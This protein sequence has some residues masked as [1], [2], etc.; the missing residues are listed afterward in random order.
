MGKLKSSKL[1]NYDIIEIILKPFLYMGFGIMLFFGLIYYSVYILIAKITKQENY[2]GNIKG[3]INNIR[4]I[5]FSDT[6][7]KSRE[8]HR[9]KAQVKKSRKQSAEYIERPN[10]RIYKGN[11]PHTR[12]ENN[13]E[14]EEQFQKNFFFKRLFANAGIF[15]LKEEIR[16]EK[17]KEIDQKY[18]VSKTKTSK[19]FSAK[20]TKQTA[21]T[22]SAKLGIIKASEAAAEEIKP[23][24]R[25][26]WHRRIMI[27][28]AAVI[29]VCSLVFV[30]ALAYAQELPEGLNFISPKP[31]TDLF[32]TTVPVETQQACEVIPANEES[33]YIDYA[34]DI[35]ASFS[36]SEQKGDSAGAEVEVTLNEQE[37]GTV[38]G[39]ITT[40]PIIYKLG[41]EDPEIAKIQARLM[42]LH[43]MRSTEVT[44]YYGKN[45]TY[46]MEYFQRQ[47]GLQV[48]G[49]AGAETLEVL[50]S[51][52]AEEYKLDEGTEGADVEE[53]QQRLYELSY[54]SSSSYVTGYF[55][56]KTA[57][58]VKDFQYTNGLSADGIVG[59]YTYNKL[60]SSS[61]IKNTVS[62]SSSSSSSSG[63]T[64]TGSGSAAD[65]VAVAKSLMNQG[66]IYVWGG[67]SP[68]DG[69]FDCSGFVYYVLNQA[70][71]RT[72]YKDTSAWATT[73]SFTTVEDMKDVKPGDVLVFSSGHVAIYI[74]DGKMIHSTSK[75]DSDPGGIYIDSFFTSYRESVWIWG[76]RIAN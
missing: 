62:S 12:T 23:L 36:S 18:P 66:Y 46:A 7:K 19:Y 4:S 16:R 52:Q 15:F 3:F 61:A 35:D 10:T 38:S 65:I 41:D 24:I 9:G 17:Q 47:H 55:G 72:G 54:L 51:D 74:G 39:N 2:Y 22:K 28:S 60:F 50:Y 43:Y 68:S 37:T 21:E 69:G 59:Y 32:Q 58:A 31:T 45:T 20:V 34:D 33:L 49:T 42:E 73:T 8:Q 70:G 53:V 11:R 6:I 48:D 1:K 40:E 56:T 75:G 29:I 71:I 44:E 13:I 76:K 67:K 25:P 26:I 64:V 63:T 5:V 30:G 14:E 57:A 27:G